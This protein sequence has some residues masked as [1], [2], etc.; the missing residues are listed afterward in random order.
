MR[1]TTFQNVLYGTARVLG[2]DPYR[3]L[4]PARAGTLTE[5]INN[6]LSEGWCYDYWPEWTKAEKRTY[7]D[8]YNAS[9]NLMATDERFHIASNLYYQALQAQTPATQAPAT[10]NGTAWVENSAF[11]ALSASSYTANDWAAGT[12]YAIGN[13]VRNPDDG[14]FYQC[15]SAH[16]SGATFDATKFGLLTPFNRYIAYEQTGQTKIGAVKRLARKNPTIFAITPGEI[17]FFPSTDGLQVDSTAPNQ[18]WVEFRLRPPVFDATL[19]SVSATY[20]LGDLRYVPA[21]GDCYIALAPNTALPPQNNP[22]AWQPVKFPLILASFVKRAA[23]SDAIT[24]Q[25]QTDRA[26]ALL[27][28]TPGTDDRGAYGELEDAHDR[29]FAGQ[30]QY[31]RAEVQTYGSYAPDQRR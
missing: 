28:G 9:A 27:R 8:V 1:A 25:K 23:A 10:F 18:V 11:W 3:D 6:R 19:W 4:N 2:L 5:Y 30:G 12:A 15:F 24:D 21:T 26:T 20:A 29:E 22:N 17:G 14:E 16:T 7:R 13:Q 31:S